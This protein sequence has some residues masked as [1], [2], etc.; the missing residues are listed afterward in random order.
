MV[1]LYGQDWSA[2]TSRRYVGT[3]DQLAGITVGERTDGPGRGVRTLEV[4]TGSG[5]AFT[6]L[7]ERSR[8]IGE[9][10][11]EGVPLTWQSAM[12]VVH[13]AHGVAPMLRLFR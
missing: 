9:A 8:D 13:P 12:G 2:D 6:V 11:L 7:P 3:M 1:K 4:Q 10:R 5:L